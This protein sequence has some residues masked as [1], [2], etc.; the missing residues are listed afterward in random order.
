M[1][2]PALRL[3]A[4]VGAA[5]LLQGCYLLS[6]TKGQLAILW[7]RESIQ[8]RLDDGHALDPARRRSFELVLAARAF[9]IKELGLAE[10]ESY[11]TYYDTG[12]E[13]V[14]WNVSAAPKD[15]LQPIT[16]SFPIVGTIPYLGFFEKRPALEELRRLAGLGYDALLLPVPA[17][18]TLGWFDDPVFTSLLGDD[19][20][21]IVETVIHELTHATV[22]IPGDVNLNEN[23]ATFVGEVGAREFFRARGGDEDPGLLQ[24]ARNRED[25]EVFNEAMNEL[26]EELARIYAASG[27]RARKLELKAAA[28]AGFRKRYRRELRPRL[29]DDGYDWILDERIQLNN[30]LILQFRRYHGDQPLLEGLFLRCGERLPAFVLALQEIAEADDPRAAL[31]A[32]AAAQPKGPPEQ[33]PERGAPPET[34]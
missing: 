25:S 13:P 30:A 14:A 33:A 9:A 1:P 4:I 8:E 23:L 28:V 12:G 17:Y 19:E 7:G 6:Q 29:S 24:A 18:S 3:L 15:S 2:R 10:S 16:W 20:A 22:W 5:L 31:E 21:R 11:T 34:R 27:P 32:A 26:R